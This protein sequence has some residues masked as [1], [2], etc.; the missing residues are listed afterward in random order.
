MC[1]CICVS[2]SLYICVCVLGNKLDI[3]TRTANARGMPIILYAQDLPTI[4]AEYPL[5][6]AFI[7]WISIWTH[8]QSTFMH[9]YLLTYLPPNNCEHNTRVVQYLTSFC[10]NSLNGKQY[11]WRNSIRVC[12]GHSELCVCVC[13]WFVN[14]ENLASYIIQLW[15][16]ES[17]IGV[18]VCI[19][20]KYTLGV[21]QRAHNPG[22]SSAPSRTTFINWSERCRSANAH[23][24][25]YTHKILHPDETLKPEDSFTHPL[26][27]TTH[28][29]ARIPILYIICSLNRCALEGAEHE[30]STILL[31]CRVRHIRIKL[32]A[33]RLHRLKG[34]T[35]VAYNT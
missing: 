32:H 6:N 13:V 22:S 4:Y 31:V 18:C 34:Y 14:I 5:S 15:C 10:M 29:C 33:G 24:D 27:I 23:V 3:D 12:I 8:T 30:L 11:P 21:N 28:N 1:W 35:F 19:L 17:C 9:T 16:K 20:F 26:T 2:D 7:E 25:V